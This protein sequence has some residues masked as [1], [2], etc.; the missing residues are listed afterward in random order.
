[1]ISII[2]ASVNPSLLMKL[3]ENIALTI[4]VKFELI[5]FDN[6]LQG[7]G[8]AALYNRGAIN[9]KYDILCFAH[10]D[11]LFNTQ[12]WGNIISRIFNQQNNLGLVGVAGGSYKSISPSSWFYIDSP[13]KTRH[14][15][16]LQGYRHEAR[17]SEL[18]YVNPTN[19][20]F[21]PVVTLDGVL[22]FSKREIILNYSFDEKLLRGFHCY[23]Q[24][25][26]LHIGQHFT[27]AVTYEILITHFSEGK[28]E[29]DWI[30]Q[31]MLLHEK[32]RNSLPRASTNLTRG[33]MAKIEEKAMGFF[34]LKM[35]LMDRGSLDR[36][37]VLVKSKLYKLLGWRKFTRILINLI[38]GQY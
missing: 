15:H 28:Y 30:D 36:L 3:S 20:S 6:R 29:S 38:R 13:E 31:T 5:T 10:E 34:L 2:I 35:K 21:V 7:E 1:M 27:I 8:L 4:G 12:D 26:A 22:L 19:Q 14:L 11:I 32:W 16:I 24:D 33:E 9:A 25:I 23:D 18:V 17:S 37:T